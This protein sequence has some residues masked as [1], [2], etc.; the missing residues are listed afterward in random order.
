[1]LTRRAFKAALAGALV[2]QGSD[3]HAVT[4]AAN[5]AHPVGSSGVGLE[6]QRR[7]DLGRGRYLNP[8]VSG[9]HAD[10]TVL[11]DGAN[12][13]M[14]FSS[15]QSCPGAVIWHSQDL[16]S[17]APIVAALQV[18]IGSVWAMDLIKHEGRYYLYIPVLA[19]A[20][21]GIYVVYAD[22]IRG[23]WSA[24]IDLH[25]LG[26]IDP[27]HV[28]GEDGRRYLFVNGG[29]RV[30]LSADGLAT[31]GP[32]ESGA[33]Q[34]WQYPA[35]WVV[36]MFAPE[37][38]K[39][40]RRGEWFYLVSAVGGTAGP[41]TSHM[42]TAARARSVHGPWEHCPQNPIVRTQD[43]NEPW[44][45]RGHASVVEG[46]GG[47]WWMVYHGYENGMRT[48]GRQTLLEPIEWTVDGWFRARGGRLD[49]P[50]PKPKGGMAGP[51]GVPLSDAFT[52]PR[53][54]LQWGFHAAGRDEAARVRFDGDGLLL[55]GKGRAF[56]DCS[57][58]TCIVGDRS[59]E[60]AAEF[61]I[62][63]GV[64]GDFHCG[65]GV[66]YNERGYA[67]IAFSRSQML[68]Y[69]YGDEQRWMREE[70]AVSKVNIRMLN[71]ENVLTFH[72]S[73]NGQPW[74]QH[75]WQMEVSGMHHNVFGGFLSLKAALFSAG[76][77]EV[78]IRNFVYR[79]LQS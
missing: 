9:D 35:D 29:R 21:T 65:L 53:L 17:W 55:E 14:T 50:L 78:R 45:S 3:A 28:V 34:P 31:D 42:V 30:R 20:G 56:G 63:G 64:H 54:G 61:E 72:Y 38:P 71:R 11:K 67:G 66:F 40:F 12:Y 51:A 59:Y 76:V 79:G 47:D 74:K 57:P 1:M 37:G 24:P 69:G 15:F 2:A 62:Q 13:Y 33:W 19:D 58:L 8:I 32:V 68:T 26:C 6:G 39:L 7:A 49:K 60:V 22:D 10:P 5:R 77:G 70:M 27:G 46:P 75:A 52:G 23:P 4:R 41:P 44:W 25:V 48:L 43:A 36:E 18:P 73:V 16:V